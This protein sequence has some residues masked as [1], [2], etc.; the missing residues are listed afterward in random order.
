MNSPGSSRGRKWPNAPK[1]TTRSKAG[2]NGS[3]RAS[4]RTQAAAGPPGRVRSRA[5]SSMPALKSTPVTLR[6]HTPASTSMPAPSTS[7]TMPARV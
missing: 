6:R 7:Q 2:P 3:A 1:L 4:A 5:T